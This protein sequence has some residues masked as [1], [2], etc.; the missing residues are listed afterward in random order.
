M[1]ALNHDTR[2]VMTILFVGTLSGANVFFYAQYGTSFPYGPLAHSIL[3]G[4]GT[5]GSIM[6]MKAIFDLALNDRIEL[7][8][9]DRKISAYW[10][11]KARDA[12][13][14]T[15]LVE[16]AKQ[17]SNSFGMPAFQQQPQMLTQD[18]DGN[19]VSNEFLIGLQ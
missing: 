12:E 2:L 5:I 8:L 1:A 10:A 4:L 11:R 16:S 7:M 13:Q 14:R 6:V 15:K 18:N 17:Y 19:S 9:L 3:F